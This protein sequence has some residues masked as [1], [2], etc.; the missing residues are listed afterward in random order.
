MCHCFAVMYSERDCY[1]GHSCSDTVKHIWSFLGWKV[2]VQCESSLNM[3]CYIFQSTFRKCTHSLTLLKYL[4]C[5]KL[6]MRVF[7][8]SKIL[9][10]TF[11]ISKN[12]RDI[13]SMYTRLHVIYPLFLSDFNG[14][15]IFST[16]FW[17]NSKFHQNPSSVS[18]GFPCGRADGQRA[19][20][21]KRPVRHDTHLT[22]AVNL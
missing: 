15:I 9:S 8:V 18:R 3:L 1:F 13:I 10:E 17:K 21:H 22:P 14:I 6:K 16:H 19:V 2:T 20:T 5:R 4:K 7:I 11:L 12:L